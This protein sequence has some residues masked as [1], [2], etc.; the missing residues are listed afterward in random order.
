MA[1]VRLVPHQVDRRVSHGPKIGSSNYYLCGPGDTGKAELKG[2]C[3][4]SREMECEM[5][6]EQ[7]FCQH[8]LSNCH[9]QS[10]S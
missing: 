9:L 2:Q 4:A 3:K 8:V 6:T 5:C 1:R 10:G 7:T